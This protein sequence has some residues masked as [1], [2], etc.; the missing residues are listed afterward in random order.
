MSLNGALLIG[1]SALTASQAAIQVAG[2]NM[3]NASTPGYHRQVVSL[4]PSRPEQLG[5]GQF[6]GQGVLI[7][8]ISRAV[9]TALQARVRAAIGDE[10]GALI[11]QRFLSAI[12]TLQNE[13]TETDLSSLLNRFFNAVSEAANNPQDN[14]VRSVV[15]QQGQSLAD[16]LNALQEDYTKVRNEIDAALGSAVEKV[17]GLLSQVAAL[18]IQIAQTEQGVGIANSLRDQRDVIIDEISQFID[19]SV[20]DQPNGAVNLLVGSIPVVLSGESRGLDL[21]VESNGSDVDVSIR[22]RADGSLLNVGSG[23][24]GAL[25]QQRD[26]TISPAI[27]ALNTL[28]GE[29]IL[30]VNKVHSQGQGKQGFTAISGATGLSDS[31][32][33]LNAPGSGVQ[34]PVG[35]GSFLLNVTNIQSGARQTYQISVD[36]NTDSLN[37]LI[38]RINATGSSATAGLSLENGL[39]LTADSGFEITFSEDSSG[40]L[41]S[42]GVNTFFTGSNATDIA[43][44]SILQNSPDLL[45]LGLNHISGSN[46]NALAIVALQDSKISNLSG[47]SLREFWQAQVNDLAVRGDAANAAVE[48]T[49]LVRESLDAQAQAVSGVSI[50]EEAINLISFQRQF[51]AAA[52]FISVIDETLQ[53]LLNIV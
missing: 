13:L 27:D 23:Q 22:V 53:T 2:N 43:V 49:R 39:S 47:R 7:K 42:L 37:D 32:A 10:Q 20:I 28:A 44:N 17:D 3:A 34:F 29:L 41:A 24:I 26:T 51:Q 11:D 5:R 30:Q 6:V 4:T 8:Q 9:D 14:A 50:D 16:R 1:K 40:V 12:E 33:V 19:V 38:N 35:K 36:G 46:E 21:R 25:E 15:I 52:R 18:N 31:T 45:A 48:S